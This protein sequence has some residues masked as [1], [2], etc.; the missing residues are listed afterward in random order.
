MLLPITSLALGLQLVISVA[1]GVPT[2][3]IG[4]TCR[5]TSGTDGMEL[6]SADKCRQQENDA[7]DT[8]RQQWGKFPAADSSECTSTAGRAVPSYVM[9]LTCLEMA[10]DARLLPK[11]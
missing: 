9:L 6:G 3:N 7:R 8:L 11:E 4:P 1:D 10:R 2:F 5:A